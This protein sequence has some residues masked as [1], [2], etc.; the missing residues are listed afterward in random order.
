M[1]PDQAIQPMQILD[2]MEPGPMRMAAFPYIHEFIQAEQLPHLERIPPGDSPP[3][4][5]MSSPVRFTFL[6]SPTR[7]ILAPEAFRHL[8]HAH[9]ADYLVVLECSTRTGHSPFQNAPILITLADYHGHI[10]FNAGV[11]TP[12][13]VPPLT[14]PDITG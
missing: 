13:G 9:L 2:I 3:V 1:H 8:D 6:S 14:H 4:M 11:Q 7:P 10:I 12:G 5:M